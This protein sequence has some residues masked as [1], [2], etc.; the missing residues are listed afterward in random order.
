MPWLE[1]LLCAGV[2]AKSCLTLCDSRDCSPP[3]SSVH[4]ILQARIL[5]WAV[6]SYA[7]GSSWPRD[8][9]CVS[10]IGRLSL[11]R[12]ATGE[13][14]RDIRGQ[15]FC[16]WLSHVTYRILITWLGIEPELWQW[17]LP[18]PNH[19]TAREFLETVFSL[20]ISH[21]DWRLYD[22]EFCWAELPGLLFWWS[23]DFVL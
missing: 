13:T 23:T 20:L 8:Q 19:W 2:C 4:G 1:I 9:T 6:I 18:S 3:G 11:Y 12:S 17:T 5:E 22:V 21:W 15:C 16:F 10:Y 14:Q 7:G